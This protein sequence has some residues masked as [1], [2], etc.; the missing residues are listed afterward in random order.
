MP[1]VGRLASSAPAYPV[2]LFLGRSG[3]PRRIKDVLNHDSRL[4]TAGRRTA[5]L[6]FSKDY[7]MLLQSD[8]DLGAFADGHLREKTQ[9]GPRNI[10][11]GGRNLLKSSL[12]HFDL[13]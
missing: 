2:S 6:N 3:S 5:I 4:E 13:D 12:Q 8:L 1:K 9:A 10:N 11:D 7:D